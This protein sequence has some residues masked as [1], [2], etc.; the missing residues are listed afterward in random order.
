MKKIFTIVCLLALASNT[1]FAAVF[2]QTGLE[3][4]P[5]AQQWN[6]YFTR[7]KKIEEVDWQ[8]VTFFQGYVSGVASAARHQLNLPVGA[9]IDQLCMI[10]YQY[11]QEN[12]NKLHEPAADLIILALKKAFSRNGL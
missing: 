1:S 7:N 8:K 11:F 2:F 3:L 12:S 10:V 5:E 6:N 9:Q 4:M